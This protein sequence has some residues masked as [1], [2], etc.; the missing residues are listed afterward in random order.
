MSQRCI[1][2]VDNCRASP[3]SS[4]QFSRV[5]THPSQ[6]YISLTLPEIFTSS[7]HLCTRSRSSFWLFS[8]CRHRRTAPR[9]RLFFLRTLCS[10]REA[11]LIDFFADRWW[12]GVPTFPLD[13]TRPTLLDRQD[14]KGSGL[15]QL[16]GGLEGHCSV[17]PCLALPF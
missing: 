16:Q 6:Q 11:R 17:L 14:S 4:L 2:C 1:P 12:M 8:S 7:R 13:D 9:H 15:L 5:A 3:R 10:S